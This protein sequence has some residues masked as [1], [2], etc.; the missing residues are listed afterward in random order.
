[1]LVNPSAPVEIARGILDYLRAK[2]FASPSDV[3]GRLRVRGEGEEDGRRE[4]A[5][6]PEP[7]R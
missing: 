7:V 3:R 5:A 1:M 6:A 4:T 2:G